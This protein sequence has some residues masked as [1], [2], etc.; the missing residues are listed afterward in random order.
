M[1]SK[2]G[3]KSSKSLESSASGAKKRTSSALSSINGETEILFD[4]SDDEQSISRTSTPVRTETHT[5]FALGSAGKGNDVES[6]SEFQTAQLS[7]S[8]S[9]RGVTQQ[10]TVKPRKPQC[11]RFPKIHKPNRTG[12]AFLKKGTAWFGQNRTRSSRGRALGYCY[13]KKRVG[14]KTFTWRC[15][16]CG[17]VEDP[18]KATITQKIKS[19][20]DYFVDYNQD[21][22]KENLHIPNGIPHNHPPDHGNHERA[23]K[24]AVKGKFK[25]PRRIVFDEIKKNKEITGRNM[26]DIENATWRLRYLR[27]KSLPPNPRIDEPL[28]DVHVAFFPSDFHQGA[29]FAGTATN[30]ARHLLFFTPVF[31]RQLEDCTTWFIDA[32]FHFIRDPIKKFL[33]INGFIKNEKGDL[34]QVPLL[35]CC[36]TRKRAIDYLSVFQKLKLCLFLGSK[37]SSLTLNVQFFGSP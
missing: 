12:L 11:D 28:F 2:R 37:E 20:R 18:C 29:V 33:F 22:F 31:K 14:G 1:A 19:D 27:A 10:T 4:I 26:P 13:T 30:R 6:L 35:F 32:T 15:S 36:M 7:V 8:N 24:D 34:E 5:I 23:K 21:D 3:S 17:R 25:P 9:N 16:S